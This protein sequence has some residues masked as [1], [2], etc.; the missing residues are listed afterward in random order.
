M[1]FGGRLKEPTAVVRRRV[2]NSVFNISVHQ[3]PQVCFVRLL[4]VSVASSVS[5]T[6][7]LSIRLDIVI[8]PLGDMVGLYKSSLQTNFVVLENREDCFRSLGRSQSVECLRLTTSKIILTG[9]L[10]AF[11]KVETRFEKSLSVLK[12]FVADN[13]FWGPDLVEL[14]RCLGTPVLNLTLD[15]SGL[16]SELAFVAL[17]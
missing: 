2:Q 11:K 16:V 17:H 1:E 13:V 7:H 9:E 6:E 12:D 15:V 10:Q 3:T 4:V 8:H 14:N 5:V